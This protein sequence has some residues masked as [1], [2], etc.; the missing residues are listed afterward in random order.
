[1]RRTAG[2]QNR[3]ELIAAGASYFALVATGETVGMQQ[4]TPTSALVVASLERVERRHDG[5]D[6]T[7]TQNA[8]VA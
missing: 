1:M 2:W 5:T 3:L 7:Q 4:K 6:G 8:L